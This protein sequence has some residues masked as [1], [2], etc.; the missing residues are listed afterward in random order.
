MDRDD[1]R[2]D[3]P[4]GFVWDCCDEPGDEKKGCEVGPHEAVVST[5]KRRKLSIDVADREQGSKDE[6]IVL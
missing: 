5:R 4:D 6:P 1:T 2:K 3:Y